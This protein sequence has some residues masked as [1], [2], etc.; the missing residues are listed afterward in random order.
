[1]RAAPCARARAPLR[2]PVAPRLTRSPPT[3]APLRA[4]FFS[5]APRS[6][7]AYGTQGGGEFAQFVLRN[8]AL[9]QNVGKS[10]GSN[11]NL[12]YSFE[13]PHVHWIA[14][15]AESWTMS[16]GQLA[17]QKAWMTQDLSSVDRARTPWVIAFSHKAWQMDSTTWSMFD[18][19]PEY[20]V[21][22]HLVGHW[23]QV[24]PGSS[25]AGAAARVGAAPPLP[26]QRCSSLTPPAPSSLAPPTPSVHAL[27]PH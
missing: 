22:L 15:C 25:A 21:D 19:L 4:L 14:F 24:R 23:H 9:A 13:T 18:I 17:Q 26:L 6:H 3:L 12:W 27:P 7:E 11:S 10:S 20:K 2:H 8:R 16:A 5:R 1:M